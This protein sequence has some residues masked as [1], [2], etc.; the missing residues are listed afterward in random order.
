MED[1]LSRNPRKKPETDF[2]KWNEK[3][4][5]YVK[6]VNIPS[7]FE[8]TQYTP[9]E[10]R[11]LVYHINGDIKIP[12]SM[13]LTERD[14]FE[15]VAYLNKNEDKYILPS[16]I[17]KEISTSSLLFLGYSLE[18]INF[19]AIFQGFLSFMSS[20]GSEFRRPSIAVQIPPTISRKEQIRMQKYLE[21]YTLNLFDV[22][23]YW[24]NPQDFIADIEKRWSEFKNK[25]NLNAYPPARGM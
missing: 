12:G 9:S 11:P 13:V 1:A 15:F 14:Y 24:G 21:R 4:I 25:N 7:I 19:R 17:R 16:V 23:V 20:I 5:N 10:D 6:A 2:C 8:D 3:L 22:R 18:D